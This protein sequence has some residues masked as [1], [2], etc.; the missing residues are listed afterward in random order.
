[1]TGDRIEV[2]DTPLDVAEL[3]E[4]ALS[5][6]CGAVVVFSGTVRNHAEG[7]SGVTSLTYEAYREAATTKLQ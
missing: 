5:P 4:W 1:M 6:E 2:S 3:Y 7:R